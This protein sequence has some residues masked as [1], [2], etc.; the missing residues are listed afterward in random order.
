M[1]VRTP[2]A[3]S[4]P[5]PLVSVELTGRNRRGSAAPVAV[6]GVP[7]AGSDE[8]RLGPRAAEL[9]A[10]WR[11]VA[12][13]SGKAG[14][15]HAVP[16]LDEPAGSIGWVVGVGARRPADW[17]TAGAALVRAAQT[18][19]ENSSHPRTLDIS[20]PA[21]IGAD[22]IGALVLGLMLGGYRFTVTGDPVRPVLRTVRLRVESV[23]A[24][25]PAHPDLADA[26]RRASALASATALARDLSNTPSNVK[27][28]DWLARTAVAVTS[29]VPGLTVEVHD[30]RW[31]AEQGFGGILA[32]G[33]GSV[34]PPRLT[35][36]TWR[37][38]GSARAPH[39]VL[40]GKG[41]TFDTG[42]ISIKP[43]AGMHLMRTDM[44]GGAAVIAALRGIAELGLPIRVTGLVPSA[45]NH[46]S[47]SAYRPGDIVRHYG[48][49]TTQVT[50]TDAEGRLVLADALAYAA[51]TLRPDAMVDVA[52][53]T[54][55]MKVAL[56]LRIGGLFASS[57]DLAERIDMR[58]RLQDGQCCAGSR[59]QRRVPAQADTATFQLL[60]EPRLGPHCGHHGQPDDAGDVDR[61]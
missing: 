16:A 52:T 59:R 9:L 48:G 3:P 39:L 30:E 45:E 29:G 6:I 27:D 61:P 26:V 56:G 33:A 53:L 54:G 44:S 20:L 40:V 7:P 51:K 50:N 21:G 13:P 36:L 2:L 25:D 58:L 60:F 17:R 49:R 28:P 19:G 22:E 38:A 8:P 10:G 5:T 1:V 46:V 15:V 4:V 55:A 11:D 31:L 23:D 14:E 32:V 42:G 47:G 24:Q 57:D 37:P 43:A 35:K 41:I 34:R 12:Q 18:L